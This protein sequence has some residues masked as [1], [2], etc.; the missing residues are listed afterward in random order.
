[1]MSDLKRICIGS[2]N[3]GSNYGYKNLKINKKEILKI[4]KFL[5]KKKIN[6]IDTAINYKN[7]EKV[8]GKYN[9]NFQIITK[10]PYV[11]KLE[12]NPKKW[13][14]KRISESLKNLK[15]KK[16]YGVLF[17]HPPY[18][19]SKKDFFLIIKYLEQLRKKKIIK[20][21]GISVY[22]LEEL[23]K[24]YKIYNFQIVQFPFN[25]FDNRIVKS[26]FILSLK[27]DNVELHARSIFLQGLL[28][29]D[30][31]YFEKK[32]KT[33]KKKIILFEKWL[34]KNNL[35]KLQ[36]CLKF[37]FKSKIIDKFVIG[38]SK[39]DQITEIIRILKKKITLDSLPNE[40]TNISPN[41][42]NPKSW[43]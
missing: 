40:L 9:R 42:L 1:M 32:F 24:C 28:L 27:K 41:L 34:K 43:N 22:T 3:F 21:I 12:K 31:K 38:I 35:N 20:K 7:S 39:Y 10:I 17:H 30:S 23:K 8:I 37:A 16:L 14:E 13:I 26:R 19:Y 15:S 5:K 25:I 2:A 4:F 11:P 18:K 33:H 29:E 36:A 6:Y